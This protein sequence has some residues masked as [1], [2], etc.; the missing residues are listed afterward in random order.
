MPEQKPLILKVPEQEKKKPIN[1]KYIALAGGAGV[2]ALDLLQDGELDFF[3][4]FDDDYDKD[5]IP[6]DIEI[7][8][9]TNP[10]L[11]DSDGDGV[12]DFY[13]YNWY[14][15]IDPN[16]GLETKKYIAIDLYGVD[17]DGNVTQGADGVVDAM[18]PEITEVHGKYL[19][20]L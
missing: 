16:T 6:N 19:G 4:Y 5:G 20:I 8:Y 10:R 14:I 18:Q 1:W 11:K 9:G 2:V 7:M 3:D 17:A 12:S 13:E 15:K